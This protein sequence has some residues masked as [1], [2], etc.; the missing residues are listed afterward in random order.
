MGGQK[1]GCSSQ[2]Q[3]M[4]SFL[5]YYSVWE[6][7]RLSDRR[8]LEWSEDIS[9]VARALMKRMGLSHEEIQAI[10]RRETTG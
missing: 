8:Q 3:F 9:A 4:M 1:A 10:L 2:F 7:G 5:R 6:D